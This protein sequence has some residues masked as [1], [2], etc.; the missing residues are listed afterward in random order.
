MDSDYTRHHRNYRL[1]RARPSV[2]RGADGLGPRPRR[3]RRVR[4]HHLLHLRPP[5]RLLPHAGPRPRQAEPH[6]HGRRPI[7]PRY[8]IDRDY[9]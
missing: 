3:P 7:L 8:V 2:E 6:L 4:V 5:V 1:R 9:L